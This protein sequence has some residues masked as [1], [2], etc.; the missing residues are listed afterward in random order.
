[1][2]GTDWD[3]AA[4]CGFGTRYVLRSD[5]FNQLALLRVKIVAW[6]GSVLARWQNFRQVRRVYVCVHVKPG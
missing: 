4:A 3:G 1:L 2:A 5:K 6:F